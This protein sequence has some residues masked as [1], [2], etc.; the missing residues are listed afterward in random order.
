MVMSALCKH[1]A[2]QCIDI[3]DNLTFPFQRF[4]LDI[5][6][7]WTYSCIMVSWKWCM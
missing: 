7:W 4:L 3:Q 6:V 2:A 1:V 5:C